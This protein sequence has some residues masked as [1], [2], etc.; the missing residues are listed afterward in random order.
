MK[1][2]PLFILIFISNFCNASKLEFNF[3]D[4][5]K[6][7]YQINNLSENFSSE[8]GYTITPITILLVTSDQKSKHLIKQIL[9]LQNDDFI[10]SNEI[11]LIQGI[12]NKK[13]SSNYH[14]TQ[15][16]TNKILDEYDP[17]FNVF[18][19]SANNEILSHSTVPLSENEILDFI[20][21]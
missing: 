15:I 19:I 13:T 16:D 14:L 17:M 11:I 1:Y 10:E 20:R 18:I 3:Y 2:V 12:K 7:E 5:S 8:F 9:F 4:S 6:K 21:K